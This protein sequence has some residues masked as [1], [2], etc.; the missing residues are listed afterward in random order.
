VALV[1]AGVY[2]LNEREIKIDNSR[3][4]T[5]FFDAVPSLSGPPRFE[6]TAV[7]V[8]EADCLE[9]AA[10]MIHAGYNPCVLNMAS[11]QN[12]G[13]GVL[14]GSGAQEENLFR[15]TNLFVSLY[16]FAPYAQDYGIDRSDKSYPLN[17]NTGGIYSDRITVFRGSEHN[18]YCFLGT[19]F[20]VSIAS[21]PAINRP[22]L[23]KE[24]G[25]YRIANPLIEP[26][27]EKMR[28][29][30]R[31]AGKYQHDCLILSA[32]GCGAFQNPPKHIAAL[33]RE[34]FQETEFEHQFRLIVFAILDDHNSWQEHNPEGNVLPFI[35]IFD[36][37]KRSSQEKD[38]P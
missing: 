4:G 16:P 2:R 36:E 14:H 32:F 10:L 34:V 6:Q 35:E 17:R 25:K 18:G 20:Q 8:I 22:D 3:V 24:N 7:F 9:T 1:S 12:P 11:G 23:E 38:K 37:M 13:G 28:T 26:T 30:L 29:I 5:E 33:F 21:V 19:P 31:I 27:R 15:R